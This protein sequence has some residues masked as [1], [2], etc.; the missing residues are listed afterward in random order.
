MS[1]SAAQRYLE[2]ALK[3]GILALVGFGWY[4][5][6][7]H[8]G[9]GWLVNLQAK[10]VIGGIYLLVTNVGIT[11][12]VFL[13]VYLCTGRKTN[14]VNNLQIPDL[15]SLTD[16]YPCETH[17]GGI[18]SCS[19]NDCGSAWKPPRSHH[20]SVCGVCRL[21]FDHHC[22]WLGNCVTIQR[23]KAFLSLLIFFTVTYSIAIAPVADTLISH[24]DTALWESYFDLAAQKS[25][26]NW[27]WSWVLVSGPLGRYIVGAVLG[28]RI[29]ASE[30][31]TL[32][33]VLRGTTSY[34]SKKR[35]GRIQGA[36]SGKYIAIPQILAS[37]TD[38]AYVVVPVPN[39]ER[40][41]DLGWKD[42]LRSLWS[43]PVFSKGTLLLYT[44]PKLNPVI[45]RSALRQ[46]RDI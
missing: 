34:E 3:L 22:P 14:N 37:G 46:S 27:P 31:M 16:P 2:N 33:D 7:I 29:I 8:I 26:W 13:Y 19:R 18:A 25:W 44:W 1:H 15:S 21:D 42:N 28:F 32:R 11:A 35:S 4:L 40:L 45:V 9:L 10:W 5:V 17:Q 20:C 43:T 39:G 41:Y 36:P 6:T 12:C 24:I 23:Q 38:E 30:L